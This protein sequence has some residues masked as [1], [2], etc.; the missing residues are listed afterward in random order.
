MGVTRCSEIAVPLPLLRDTE[1]LVSFF[2]RFSPVS[3]GMP[4]CS[5]RSRELKAITNFR[6]SL[7]TKPVAQPKCGFFAAGRG[8]EGKGSVL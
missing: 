5:A 1:D 4:I 7:Y 2:L 8:E 3:G 6:M